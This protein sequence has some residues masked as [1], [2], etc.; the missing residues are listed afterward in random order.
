[1]LFHRC[2]TFSTVQFIWIDMNRVLHS[3]IKKT[4][5]RLLNPVSQKLDCLTECYPIWELLE[6]I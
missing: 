5:M 1:M 3:S 6:N 2:C 4:R